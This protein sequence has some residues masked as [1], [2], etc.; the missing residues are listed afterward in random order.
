M[1]A[2]TGIWFQESGGT[3]ARVLAQVVEPV[4][5][6]RKRKKEKLTIEN[7]EG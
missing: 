2:R 4:V 6:S 1:A 7:T 3:C 5:L